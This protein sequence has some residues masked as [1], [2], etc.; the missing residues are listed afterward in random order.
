MRDEGEI[1]REGGVDRDGGGVGERE[2]EGIERGYV[3]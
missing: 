3:F 2:L 1:W